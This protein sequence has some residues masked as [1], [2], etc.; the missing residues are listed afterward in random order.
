MSTFAYLPSKEKLCDK[1]HKNWLAVH[2]AQVQSGSIIT[3]VLQGSLMT[4]ILRGTWFAV[5]TGRLLS[6]G[7]SLVKAEKTG[8]DEVSTNQSSKNWCCI[9]N[10]L[11]HMLSK[12]QQM[13]KWIYYNSCRYNSLKLYNEV[14]SSQFSC[15]C[16]KAAVEEKC[17]TNLQIIHIHIIWKTKHLV[18]E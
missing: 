6:G 5:L 10:L 16:P 15:F 8:R 13:M 18:K 17:N 2:I 3:E 11:F 7:K 4:I 14:R 9:E 1:Y 12:H